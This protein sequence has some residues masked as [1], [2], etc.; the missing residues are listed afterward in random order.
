MTRPV[1]SVGPETPLRDGISLLLRHGFA[2]L[3]V[4]DADDRV[5]GVFTEADALR[6]GAAG[7][8]GG[9]ATVGGAMTTPVEAVTGDTDVS[10]VARRLLEDRRRCVPVV[11]EGVLIGVISRRDL[12]W[13]L[14]REDDSIAAQLRRTLADY[15]GRGRRWDVDVVGGRATIRGDFSDVAERRVV[16]VLA[17]TVPGV[18]DTEVVP[19]VFEP[20]R[21]S[22]SSAR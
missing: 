11:H 8:V 12:L 16:D 19:V 6:C 2:G 3:P 10:R 7:A 4:V 15:S 14:V 5:I 9:D 13:R 20:G 22:G 21:R 18:T 17:R 1:V